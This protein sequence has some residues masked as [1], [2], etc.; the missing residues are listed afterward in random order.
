LSGRQLFFQTLENALYE[1]WTSLFPLQFKALENPPFI[2]CIPMSG[3]F[4][5]FPF[6]EPAGLR[7]RRRFSCAVRLGGDVKHG[8]DQ[9][10]KRKL[11]VFAVLF[12]VAALRTQAVGF[13]DRSD[14][15]IVATCL[16]LEA[17]GEGPEGMQAVLNVILNRAG[18]NLY[19]MVPETLRY[20]AF[21]CMA[22]VWRTEKPDFTLLFDRATEQRKAY[23]Q[24]MQLI[25][26]MEEGFLADNTCGATHYHADTI[27]P[28][29]ADS[30]RYLTTIGRHI[31][32]VERG[33]EVA[34]L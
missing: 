27:R 21:S 3:N 5:D 8:G 23:E 12:A 10:M 17:G 28:Y 33:H 30:L 32:Y 34:S 25:D 4:S 13:L 20:G 19:R 26:L 9:N 15:Q 1:N 16:V 2:L 6:T 22:S 11:F 14:R 7:E 18:G 24:A 31:F 29:W